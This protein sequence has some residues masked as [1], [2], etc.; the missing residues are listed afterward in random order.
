MP[1]DTASA[2]IM[3]G[4]R[5]RHASSSEARR[6]F[7][8]GQFVLTANFAYHSQAPKSEI[9]RA[10]LKGE[11]QRGAL[12]SLERGLAVRADDQPVAVRLERGGVVGALPGPIQREVPLDPFRARNLFELSGRKKFRVRKC[13]FPESRMSLKAHTR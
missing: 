11:T 13:F 10:D 2:I 12:L 8:L 7:E 5:A 9:K 1:V 4:L 6:R 3:P